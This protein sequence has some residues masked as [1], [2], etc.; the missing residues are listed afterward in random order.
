M[1]LAEALLERARLQRQ[2][3]ELVK[4]IEENLRLPEG[5]DPTG[6]PEELFRLYDKK[7]ERL[8]ELVRRINKTNCL[9]EMTSGRTLTDAIAKRDCLTS[10]V[11]VYNEIYKKLTEH[12]SGRYGENYVKYLRHAD[13]KALKDNIDCLSQ[14]LSDLD[15]A[16]QGKNWTVD[17]LES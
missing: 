11:R 3:R 15:T 1:K 7:M 4:Y 9:T 14:E 12:Y 16:I 8:E 10:Q 13:H 17:L 5:E 2:N 6:D